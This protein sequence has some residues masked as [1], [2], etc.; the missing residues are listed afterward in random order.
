MVLKLDFSYFISLNPQ[1]MKSLI[2]TCSQT[3][4]LVLLGALLVGFNILLAQFMPKEHALDLK[5][6]YSPTEAYDSIS[7]L[8]EKD[9]VQY[10]WAIL[11][12][13][14]PYLMAYAC[15]F[16]GLLFRLKTNQRNLAIPF[17]VALFDFF[18]NSGILYLLSIFPEE[19]ILTATIASISSTGKWILVVILLF[20][21]LLGIVKG[22]LEKK[23]GS[24]PAVKAKI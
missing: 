9:R 24:D 3:R 1:Q 17:L 13:D 22:L 10:A 2:Q 12:F 5:F 23:I 21:V 15:F 19:S 4:Y 7:H 20:L 8:E 11:F 6:A 18:E 14:M 16:S